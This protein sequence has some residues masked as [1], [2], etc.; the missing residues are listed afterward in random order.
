LVKKQYLITGY[1]EYLLEKQLAKDE[2]DNPLIQIITPKDPN[3]RGSQLSII[4]NRSLEKVQKNLDE[5]GI[6]CDIRM[7]N[8]MRITPVVLYTRYVDVLRFVMTL[9]QILTIKQ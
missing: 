9:K 1:L 7:P 8:V 2:N 4:F 6:V 3:R 5:R